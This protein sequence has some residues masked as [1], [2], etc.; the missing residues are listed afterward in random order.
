MFFGIS[1]VSSFYNQLLHI[2]YIL[3][4]KEKYFCMCHTLLDTTASAKDK[5]KNFIPL[6]IR[7][8]QIAK[9]GCL[10]MNLI[11]KDKISIQAKTIS[12]SYKASVQ[13]NWVPSM[14]QEHVPDASS[15]SN[16][17]AEEDDKFFNQ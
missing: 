11:I 8:T 16:E 17:S 6:S 4:T 9:N 15:S 13:I 3:M 1:H 10:K 5:R 12:S 14:L 2:V 7:V